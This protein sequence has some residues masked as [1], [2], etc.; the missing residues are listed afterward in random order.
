[1]RHRPGGARCARSSPRIGSDR[2]GSD[3]IGSDRIADG[4]HPAFDWTGTRAPSALF[5]VP[6]AFAFF[7][8]AGWPQVWRHNNDLARDGAEL[9]AASLGTSPRTE[10]GA[11]MQVVRLPSPLSADEAR[12][13][14]R[15]LLDQHG[16][17]APVTDHD[18]WQWVR[19]SAQLYNTIADYERLAGALI[20]IAA[21]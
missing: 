16:V 9:V 11:A 12:A 14:E 2:I 1:M 5:A 6:A 21:R 10:L 17:V 18:G 3:R 15:E 20:E 19:V 7:G 4:Y 13:L 8:A